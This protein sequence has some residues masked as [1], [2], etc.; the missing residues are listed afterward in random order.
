ML[1]AHPQRSGQ[2]VLLDSPPD[3]GP[4]AGGGLQQA[5]GLD[6]SRL[7]VLFRLVFPN[8]RHWAG[9][10]ADTARS[11]GDCYPSLLA[12]EAIVTGHRA[13]AHFRPPKTL[14]LLAGFFIQ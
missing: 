4:L 5:L 2:S 7:G 1:V 13:T 10:P 6:T 14:D 12:K 9:L 3:R 8:G 11:A